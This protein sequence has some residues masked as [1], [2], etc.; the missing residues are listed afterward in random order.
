[1]V[2]KKLRELLFSLEFI[3][4]FSISL[5]FYSATWAPGFRLIG[6]SGQQSFLLNIAYVSLA[7][8]LFA[9]II[10]FWTNH[11]HFLRHKIKTLGLALLLVLIW[12]LT[13]EVGILSSFIVGAALAG[14]NDRKLFISIF[15]S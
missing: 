11:T 8:S 7:M 12:T 4:I 3:A 9:S 13:R 1:M 2:A 5:Y 10:L 15:I 14:A 6:E